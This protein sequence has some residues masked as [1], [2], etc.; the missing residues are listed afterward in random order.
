MPSKHLFFASEKT[1]APIFF[2]Y[3]TQLIIDGINK[4]LLHT[5]ITL[6]SILVRKFTLS[7]ITLN[8]FI[9]PLFTAFL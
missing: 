3:Q 9:Y 5:I 7:I 8:N 2:L 6:K 1:D 4:M